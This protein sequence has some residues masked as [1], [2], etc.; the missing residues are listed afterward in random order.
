MASRLEK[1]G[2]FELHDLVVLIGGGSMSEVGVIVRVGRED[3]TV[4]NNHGITHKK[5]GVSTILVL[6]GLLHWM[7]RE[8]KFASATL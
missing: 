4:V 8:I 1:L 5:F 7:H 3:F 2:G 6:V